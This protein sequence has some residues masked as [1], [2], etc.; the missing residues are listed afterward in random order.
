[1]ELPPKIL[2]FETSDVAFR[3]LRHW[4]EVFFEAAGIIPLSFASINTVL[5]A[6]ASKMTN[7]FTGSDYF[8][9]AIY[10]FTGLSF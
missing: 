6:G 5:Q 1:M 4:K 9:R 10:H 8:L 2:T 7:H 3:F